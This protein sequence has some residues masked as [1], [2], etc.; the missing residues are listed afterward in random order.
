MNLGTGRGY[1]VLEVV[2]AF[3]AASGRP[4]PNR[5]APR[6]PGDVAQ[7]YADPHLARARAGLESEALARGNVRRRLALAEPQ[8]RRLPFDRTDTR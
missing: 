5:F 1:S 7:C 8:P 3:E 4:V 6:R 2:R